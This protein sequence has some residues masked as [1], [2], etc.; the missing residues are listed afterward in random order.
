MSLVDIRRE[1]HVCVVTLQR[2][3]KLNALSGA[4][5]R[6]L[7]DA[8]GGED[9]RG[10]RCVVITGAGKAFSA[11]A[12]IN[13][14]AEADAA[15]IAAYYA[16]TG[17]VYERIAA[18][19]DADDRGHP[20]LVSRRR[21]RA[22]ARNR[23]PHRRR[24]RGV[25]AAR[26]RARHP[27]QLRRRLPA[28]PPARARKGEGADA[29]APAVRRGSRR[30]PSASSRRSF[31]KGRRSNAL[32]SARRSSPPCR[33]SPSRRSSAPPTSSPRLRGKRRC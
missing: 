9:V 8:L 17:D 16:G 1:E 25:R 7:L 10:S 15:S 24:D 18:L 29:P 23:L 20:R 30:S 19:P 33:R 22:G 4:M 5:E 26:G 3:E 11:G 12:D 28:R 6:E 14:F 31:R 27:A 32:S 13:E 21:A 2:E